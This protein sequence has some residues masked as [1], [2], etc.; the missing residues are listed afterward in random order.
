MYVIRAYG[1]HVGGDNDYRVG[2][3]SNHFSPEFDGHSLSHVHV[4]DFYAA[5]YDLNGFH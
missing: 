3:Q 1:H 4:C 5:A 2:I